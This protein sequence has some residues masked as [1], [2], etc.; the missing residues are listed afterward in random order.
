MINGAIIALGAIIMLVSILHTRHFARMSQLI[1]QARRHQMRLFFTLHQALM[2]FFFLGYVGALIAIFM[3]YPLLSETFVSL[4]FLFGSV[5][6]YL[7]VTV[8][9]RLLSELEDRG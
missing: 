3:K 6:V 7:S 8:Q 2:V 4:L 9:T 1:P 5:F